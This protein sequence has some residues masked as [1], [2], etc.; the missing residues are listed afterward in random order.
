M[1]LYIPFYLF[2]RELKNPLKFVDFA[3]GDG[4]RVAEIC[5]RR[6]IPRNNNEIVGVD[7]EPGADF[8][9]QADAI[10]FLRN[11]MKSKIQIMVGNMDFIKMPDADTNN[12]T[13]FDFYFSFFEFLKKSL[14]NKG[15]FY[16]TVP[17]FAARGVSMGLNGSGF[18]ITGMAVGKGLSCMPPVNSLSKWGRKHLECSDFG[19]VTVAGETVPVTTPVRF[20]T[21]VSSHCSQNTSAIEINS[22]FRRFINKIGDEIAPQIRGKAHQLRNL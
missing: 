3:A 22:D 12:S 16:L 2:M 13:Y 11:L 1:I 17:I 10:E 21:K 5:D 7:I 18:H 9:I 14:V 8:L 6:N 19:Y 4:E 20:E 15:R